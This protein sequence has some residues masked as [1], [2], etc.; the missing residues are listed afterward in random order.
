MKKMGAFSKFYMILIFSFMYV[1]IAGDGGVQ[2]NQSKSRTFSQALRWTGT[3][4]CS[5]MR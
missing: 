1:P 3:G 4:I 2:L 5:A